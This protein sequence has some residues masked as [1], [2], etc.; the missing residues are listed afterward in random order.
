MEKYPEGKR[1]DSFVCRLVV[2]KVRSWPLF[3]NNGHQCAL[4]QQQKQSSSYPT[5]YRVEIFSPP[6]ISA[7][8]RPIITSIPHEISWKSTFQVQATLSGGRIQGRVQ[9]ALSNPGF[10]T[11]GVGMGQR[12]IMMGFT[13]DAKSNSFTVTAPSDPSVMPPGIYLLFMVNDGI[14]SVGSWV[15]LGA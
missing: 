11:H 12:M 10:H 1:S 7:A 8:E 9:I 15:D 14:P 5:E 4:H 2:A 13:A 6:Y 3:N